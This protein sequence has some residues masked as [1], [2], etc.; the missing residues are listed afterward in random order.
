[1]HGLI[2]DLE[3]G[4]IKRVAFVVPVRERRGRCRSMSWR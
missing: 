3:D 1:M 2:Q 4:Y